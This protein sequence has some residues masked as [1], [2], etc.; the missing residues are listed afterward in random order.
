MNIFIS[1][2]WA[3]FEFADSTFNS[4]MMR[5]C[6]LKMIC[7]SISFWLAMDY[8]SFKC[9]K[10]LHQPI[11]MFFVYCFFFV[12]AQTFYLKSFI[13]TQITF[14][15][16]QSVKYSNGSHS[17]NNQ[18]LTGDLDENWKLTAKNAIINETNH[19][20]GK[21]AIVYTIHTYM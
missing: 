9:E 13:H 18:I 5:V 17:K 16:L 2:N 15:K 11:F 21:K 6:Q 7:V 19:V 1:L 14:E 12:I 8:Y 10:K 20:F 4:E 3:L